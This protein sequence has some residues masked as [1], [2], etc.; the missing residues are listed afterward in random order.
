MTVYAKLLSGDLLSFELHEGADALS[1]KTKLYQE[2]PEAPWGSIVLRQ[3]LPEW[4]EDIDEIGQLMRMGET[5]TADV[6]DP[7]LVSQLFD[8]MIVLVLIDPSIIQPSVVKQN[9]FYVQKRR[10][11]QT[12]DQY[13]IH[14]HST[15]EMIEEDSNI[16]TSVTVVHDTETNQWALAST[17]RALP[18]SADEEPL[19]RET[20]E[21]EWRH[22]PSICLLDA[23]QRIP[24]DHDTLVMIQDIFDQELWEDESHPY[25]DDVPDYDQEPGEW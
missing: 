16:I 7:S 20:P 23:P 2:I 12:C 18:T 10:W 11:V 15:V 21:T 6:C 8:G 5:L 14:F 22:A 9:P 25:W 17:F 4:E 19:Y 3:D 13:I 24:R 1:L